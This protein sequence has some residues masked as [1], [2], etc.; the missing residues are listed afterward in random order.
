M[1]YIQVVRERRG[2]KTPSTSKP[3]EVEK[4][5]EKSSKFAK[6]KTIEYIS[7]TQQAYYLERRLF[8]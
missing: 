1:F 5:T 2:N 6:A 3:S 8:G 4:R 7:N